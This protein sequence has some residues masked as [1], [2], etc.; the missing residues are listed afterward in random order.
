MA[1]Y[2][3]IVPYILRWE[4]GFVND[5]D[6]SGGATNLGVTIA[7]FRAYYGEQKTTEDLIHMTM[8]QWEHI[9]NDSF[10]RIIEVFKFF[11]VIAEFSANKRHIFKTG[12]WDKILGDGIRSQS[13]ANIIVD[14]CWMSGVKRV[15]KRVQKLLNVKA[16]GIFGPKTLAALNAVNPSTMFL[17]IKS[18][19]V[20]YYKEIVGVNP[21]NRKFLKGW[22]NRLN[23]LEYEG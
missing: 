3:N 10:Y 2:E 13:V 4:G 1:N 7:T 21:K 6:D 16:D 5:P 9:F 12:Y 15:I 23:A 18:A 17:C 8:G 20:D 14:W 19:R 22:L 11:H